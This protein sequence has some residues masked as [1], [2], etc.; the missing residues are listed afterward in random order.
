M[1]TSAVDG[2]TLK[3]PAYLGSDCVYPIIQDLGDYMLTTHTDVSTPEV[4]LPA[5]DR[6]CCQEPMK[7]M[8]GTIRAF[9]C[10]CCGATIVEGEHNRKALKRLFGD[11]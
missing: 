2:H 6:T 5:D 1:T 10:S 9:H 8:P 7:R 3:Q 4:Q 11:A